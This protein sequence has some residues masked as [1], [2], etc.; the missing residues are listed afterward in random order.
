MN[1]AEGSFLH[2]T[3][4]FTTYSFNFFLHNNLHQSGQ[5]RGENIFNVRFV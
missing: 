1:G 2:V 3:F 4:K 5:L